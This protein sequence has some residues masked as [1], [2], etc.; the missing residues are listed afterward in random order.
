MYM[1]VWVKNKDEH[2]RFQAV[3]PLQQ[4][5]KFDYIL[6]FYLMPA[7]NTERVQSTS[8]STLTKSW[9]ATSFHRTGPITLGPV[10]SWLGQMS[11]VDQ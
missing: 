11:L 1:V 2:M 4:L 9:V 10:S 5:N 3:F 6:L 8:D 7:Q